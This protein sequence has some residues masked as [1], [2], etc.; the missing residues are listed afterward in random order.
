MIMVVEVKYV[1]LRMYEFF[2]IQEWRK[3]F[4]MDVEKNI[5]LNGG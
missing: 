1:W 4:G 2:K 3:I 5:T